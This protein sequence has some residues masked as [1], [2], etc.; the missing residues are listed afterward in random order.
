[1]KW[2]ASFRTAHIP[3]IE[4]FP[5]ESAYEWTEWESNWSALHFSIN[6]IEFPYTIYMGQRQSSILHCSRNY[7]RSEQNEIQPKGTP[8]EVLFIYA[9]YLL[10]C[11]CMYSLQQIL[12]RKYLL[13]NVCIQIHAFIIMKMIKLKLEIKLF[14]F[15]WCCNT[16]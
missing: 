2:F 4:F 9:Q 8:M 11:Y 7:L 3:F 15:T 16:T 10:K 1:M 6:M 5:N 12:V 13:I 14:N